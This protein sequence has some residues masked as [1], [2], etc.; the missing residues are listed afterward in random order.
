MNWKILA[1]KGP[2]QTVAVAARGEQEVDW[3]AE[4]GVEQQACTLSFAAVETAEF[5]SK[6][7][8]VQAEA[9]AFEGTFPETPF[10]AILTPS[11][12]E[13]ARDQ[14]TDLFGAVELPEE[15]QSFVIK[16]A[17]RGETDACGYLV[18]GNDRAGALYGA[19]EL[20]QQ[21]GFRWL[22]PDEYDTCVPGALPRPPIELDLCQSPS[23]ITRGFEGSEDRGGEAF[24]LWMARNKLN[25]WFAAESNK[26]FCRKLCLKFI[27]GGHSVYH[28]YVPPSKYFADHPEWYGL[29]D[30]KRR[31][32]L[33]GGV[34]YNICFSNQDIRK[35][36]AE[37]M[38]EDLISGENQWV[39]IM[40]IWPLDNGLW[41]ECEACQKLG[42]T[43]DQILLL[44]HDCRQAILGARRE[45]RL[46]RE[47]RINIPAYHETLPVPTRALPPNFDHAGTLAI[48]FTIE[49]CYVHSMED[50]SCT[51]INAEMT[52]HLKDWTS[53]DC[54]FKGDV[55]I[56]EYYNVSSFASLA[57]PF[58]K[59][60]AVDI[61]F[62][63]NTGA[64]HINYM[65]VTTAYW[66]TLSLTNV[67]FAA[68]LWNHR[69]ACQSFF[70][71]YLKQRYKS[72]AGE[73]ETFYDILE[74]AMRNCKPLKH[75]AALGKLHCLYAILS[76]KGS[77][78]SPIEIFTSEHLSYAPTYRL[79]N[80]GPSLLETVQKLDEAERI[81]D[82]VS[83]DVMDPVVTRRL[84]DDLRRFRYT[85]NMVLFLYRLIRV[86]LFEN[87]DDAIHAGLE[88]RALRDVG[89][90][91]R[92][93]DLV[94]KFQQSERRRNRYENGLTAT[95][96]PRAYAELMADYGLDTPDTPGGKL[97]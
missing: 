27:A 64:R 91:L 93:E 85:K 12:L 8:D 65:H 81:I 33:N 48:F 82:Q 74:Q 18:L 54:L 31:G 57:I 89:E 30:G 15:E 71:D 22:G 37:N 61:P 21:L 34:G 83:L 47:V 41:C 40:Q 50:S 76:E 94:M 72:Y 9:R 2:F 26:P 11:A 67:Q 88:A 39:D 77:L 4:E 87:K 1:P 84:A 78:Q 44:G 32:E 86:R 73:M 5:L 29:S 36:L 19:Y 16:T 69:L 75:Y 43:T 51:E 97:A 55:M 6:L 63:Y 45:G 96:D 60:M 46:N 80:D 13:N 23:F 59:T 38:V 42:N 14:A 24:L 68:Q 52:A 90:A 92:R 62:Y 70:E 49:R 3:T 35:Q 58:P 56:G 25:S 17:R 66:G 28:R 20:L 53:P 95:W 79:E 10:V 7:P